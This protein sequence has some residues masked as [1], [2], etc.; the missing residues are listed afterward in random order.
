MPSFKPTTKARKTAVPTRLPSPSPT[1][2]EIVGYSL[3]PSQ[4]PEYETYG[5]SS[6]SETELQSVFSPVPLRAA[7]CELF[8]LNNILDND[9]VTLSDFTCG[10]AACLTFCYDDSQCNYVEYNPTQMTC[11]KATMG[12]TTDDPMHISAYR[13]NK[14]QAF[15]NMNNVNFV[16]YF[17][18]LCASN[19]DDSC[20]EIPVCHWNEGP[21]GW[22]DYTM[23]GFSGGYCGRTKCVPGCMYC[24]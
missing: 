1:E 8:T 3:V 23:G 17:N 15:Y 4:S 19:L 18:A 2:Y 16:P 14:T 20:N 13:G 12:Q 7:I 10:L 24:A 22:N 21:R 11:S 9:V 5:C 6:I